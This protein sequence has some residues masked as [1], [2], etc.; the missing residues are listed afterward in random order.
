VTQ[1]GQTLDGRYRLDA[2]LGSGGMATVYRAWDLR[3][4]R[5]VAVKIL[6]PNLAA[7][8]SFV[9]RFRQEARTMARVHHPSIVTVHDVNESDGLLYIVME[10]IEGES[11]ADRLHREH[12]LSPEALA[13]ILSSVAS[14]LAVLHGLGLVHRDVKPHNILLP[15]TGPAKLAD[16]GL[17]RDGGTTSLTLPGT[18]IGTLGYLAPELLHG[19][20]ATPASDVYA[21][22]VVA[23]EALTGQRPTDAAPPAPSALAPWLG[24]GFD[25]PLEAALGPSSRRPAIAPLA[26]AID[27]ASD[28]WARGSNPS[29]TTTI[30]A[31]GPQATPPPMVRPGLLV[32]LLAAAILVLGAFVAWS[33]ATAPGGPPGSSPTPT[34][35]ASTVAP[36]VTPSPSPTASPSPTPS[37][38]VAPST[39]A[40][41]ALGT[42]DS[43]DATVADL[44]GGPG[45]L[46]GKDA[47]TLT[48][49]AGQVR[50][51]IQRG[52]A[53]AARDA[54]ARLV[55]QSGKLA[56][57]LAGDA[58]SRLTAAAEA[59]HRAV[60]DL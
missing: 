27:A 53:P 14:G 36:T 7:D 35:G 58:S 19:A 24:T 54:A 50:S 60:A 39:A 5:A 12:V 37:P 22:G 15:T 29:D 25:G 16:F 4:D 11:L 20:P 43:F 28:D 21:F 17:A 9:A 2:P 32:A 18:A 34:Q 6:S 47:K 23:Y 31:P 52:D 42:V 56:R 38:T 1:L 57:G 40:Q 10:L 51:A 33:L 13:P 26:E 55:D 45:S 8:P 44:Q 41:I 49:L 48:D 46:K 30:I 59:V 3:L